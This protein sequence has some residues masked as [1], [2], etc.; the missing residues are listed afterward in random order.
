MSAIDD[1]LKVT[2]IKILFNICGISD[3]VYYYVTV[4]TFFSGNHKHA[5]TYTYTHKHKHT[6][7]HTYKHKHKISTLL[8]KRFG[9]LSQ[10]F[11][12]SLH[13]GLI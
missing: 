2:K 13:F 1:G 9:V 8:I 4:I 5:R 3:A 7:T 10:A 12:H 6:Y 11:S